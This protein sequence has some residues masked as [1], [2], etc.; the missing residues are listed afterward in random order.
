MKVAHLINSMFTGGAENL[1]AESVSVFKNQG[2]TVDVI[3]LNGTATPFFQKLKA[4]GCTSIVLGLQSV[5]NP[6]LI[7]K[8]IPLL[9]KYDILHV[10]LFPALYW[11]AIAKMLSFSKVKLVF[12]EHNT[13]NRRLSNA[14][15]LLFDYFIYQFYSKI[16]CI[17]AE[18]EQILHTKIAITKNKTVIILNGINLKKE[19][20]E[21]ALQP[22]D[23]FINANINT[24]FITQVAGF[25]LQKDQPTAIRAMQ[26]LPLNMILL[27]VGDGTERN[28]CQQ[29]ATQLNV[30]DRVVFLG[31]RSD[32]SLILQLSDFVILASHHEGLSL[33]SI[34]GMAS[35]KPFIASD[36]PGLCDVVIG[37]GLLFDDGDYK[38]LAGHIIH[39]DADVNFYN[40]TVEKCL[41]RAAEFDIEIMVQKEIELYK[42]LMQ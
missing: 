13:I 18:I 16:I 39:L 12:T 7:F 41:E 15:Y 17:S 23:L 20:G 26:L 30:G 10:H 5:Y 35:G 3:L 40:A 34:E 29:L 32:V 38:A 14:F 1:I 21:L 11:V 24:K 42:I 25:R 28:A 22:Q 6:L 31:V 19:T 33:S 4:T 9:K 36:V 8:I 37:A 27:L 2:L